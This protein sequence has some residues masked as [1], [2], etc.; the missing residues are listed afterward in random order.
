MSGWLSR[1]VAANDCDDA[2]LP[3]H[4]QID[5]T[6]GAALDV[7]AAAAEKI[8]NAARVNPDVVRSL[9]FPAM[10]PRETS[11][12]AQIPFQHCPQSARRGLSLRHWKRTGACDCEVCGTRLFPALARLDDKQIPEKLIYRARRGA[13]MLEC[14]A[15]SRCPSQLQRAMRA[16]TFAMSPKSFRGDPSFAV[17][18]ARPEVRLFCRAAI[19]AARSRPLAQAAILRPGIDDHARPALL[20]AFEKGPR[21][22]A[23]ADHIAQRRAT[24]AGPMAAE[25]R[26]TRRA[27][28]S[29]ATRRWQITE[30]Q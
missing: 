11:L 10:T 4:I 14:A 1:R 8:A 12:T 26:K 22:L 9:T 27:S 18:Y 16:I 24:S 3:A 23:A 5:F 21:L 25:S 2:E 20:R 7:D 6:H 29:R 19:A 30:N 17:Q 28:D 15:R 13:G